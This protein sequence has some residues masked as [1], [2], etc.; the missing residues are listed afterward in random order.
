MKR[1]AIDNTLRRLARRLGLTRPIAYGRSVTWDA[2]TRATPLA[3][4]WRVIMSARGTGSPIGGTF[5]MTNGVQTTAPLPFDADG[6][7]IR[8]AMQSLGGATPASN[9]RDRTAG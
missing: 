5:T 1:K 8:H 6:E 2:P 4:L 9:D 7:A 3:D